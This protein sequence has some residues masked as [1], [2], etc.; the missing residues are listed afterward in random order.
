MPYGRSGAATFGPL[1]IFGG[2]GL[3]VLLALG[4]VATRRS[5]ALTVT[6][7][8]V[9]PP[10]PVVAPRDDQVSSVNAATKICPQCAEQVKAAALICRFCRFEF[11]PMP[12]PG[13][14]R[15]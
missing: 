1:L 4:A 2:T 14:Q 11:G 5:G 12:P 8:L 15:S 3:G 7:H 9:P 6:H 10:A 13:Q